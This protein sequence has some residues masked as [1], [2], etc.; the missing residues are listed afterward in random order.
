MLERMAQPDAPA[1]YARRMAT[2]EPVF[3][4]LEHDMGF[5]RLSSRFTRTIG[6]EVLLKLLAHNIS[7]LL[8]RTKLFCVFFLLEAPA[9]RDA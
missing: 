2:V 5:R 9:S 7:R 3:A 8:A 4:S 6:A 1:R